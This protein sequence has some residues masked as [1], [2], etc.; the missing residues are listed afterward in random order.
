MVRIG[1]VN[2]RDIETIGHR[3]EPDGASARRLPISNGRSAN[4]FE[5]ANETGAI[6][7]TAPV[8]VVERIRCPDSCPT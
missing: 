8:F 6:A 5:A 3:G 1:R 7:R 2:D 4:R